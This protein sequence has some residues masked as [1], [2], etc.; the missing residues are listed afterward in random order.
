MRGKPSH[1]EA[2]NVF[3]V[4]ADLADR[5]YTAEKQQVV[6]IS[7][8]NNK[9]FTAK[10]KERNALQRLEAEQRHEH[11]CAKS[12]ADDHVSLA[13]CT[14]STGCTCRFIQDQS[15]RCK[16]NRQ[17]NNRPLTVCG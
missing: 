16:P 3:G 5:D 8:G 1:C 10:D 17:N 9:A 13:F 11:R 2:S 14:P 12:S 6:V 7:A 4:Q 15:Y